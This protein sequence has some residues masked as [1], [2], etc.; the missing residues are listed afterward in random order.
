MLPSQP[1]NVIVP[2]YNQPGIVRAC[3]DS[4]LKSAPNGNFEVVVVDDAST[5]SEVIRYLRAR[6]DCRE[7]TLLRNDQNVGFTQSANRG[8]KLS[9]DRDVLLL[10]SD[11]VVYGSWLERLQKAAYSGDRI[12]TANP[13]TNASHI[14]NYPFRISNDDVLLE[15]DDATLD[16]LAQ[17]NNQGRYVDV[18]TT[19]GFCMYI[20]REAI[21]SIGYFD[22]RHFPIGYGEE[23][24]FCY[25]ARRLGWRHVVA[26]DVFVRHLEN[27]SFG[28]RKRALMD[29]MIT[30]FNRLH[31]DCA[32]QDL[33]FAKL[34]PLGPLRRSLD[35]ARLKLQ[36]DSTTLPMRLSGDAAEAA[37]VA[38]SYDPR[39]SSLEFVIRRPV[40]VP[41]LESYSLP[42]DICRLNRDLC[43]L[44]VNKISFKSQ[45]ELN[46]LQTAVVG[47]PIETTLMAE[48]IV[49]S[50]A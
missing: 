41:N 9:A 8:M 10:N 31:P 24:D 26:G 36:I 4:V 6:A 7:I 35:L 17:T 30:V 39:T 47:S 42:R 44:G 48:L 27:H 20:R 45:T 29:G 22:V 11:T 32:A 21:S 18:H 14:S 50:G 28:E 12:A 43:S 23:S 46:K 40:T 34:D 33:S 2:V 38:L 1:V 19:V 37:P 3:L 16:C 49:E 25:R 13:L 15:V 5:D